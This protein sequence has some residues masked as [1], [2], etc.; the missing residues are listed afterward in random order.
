MNRRPRQSVCVSALLK[1]LGCAALLVIGSG[2]TSAVEE[3]E[4]ILEPIQTVPT[5]LPATNDAVSDKVN[6]IIEDVEPAD[7]ESINT[8]A[9]VD[10]QETS[11]PSETVAPAPSKPVHVPD[12]SGIL[13]TARQY[14]LGMIETG[15]NDSAVGGLGEVSRYQIMPSVWKHYSSSRSYRN[16]DV[17]TEVARQ[18]W[19]SLYAYFKKKNERE[20]TNFDM[21]VMWNTRH[22]HY[23]A[24]G[25]SPER[26]HPVIRDRAQRFTNLVEDSLRR[27]S[28]L[29]MANLR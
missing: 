20:P 6:L 12:H 11:A 4:I 28:E 23:A 22:G 14:A 2:V 7:T 21:Y 27:E 16:L 29:A 15:N 18:H 25:F 9:V 1:S 3:P 26:L 24:R 19:T 10:A 17:A 8:P 5:T 13:N